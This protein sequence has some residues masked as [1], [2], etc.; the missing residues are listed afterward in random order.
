M[1]KGE[2]RR[3]KLKKKEKC[4]NINDEL[5]TEEK[6]NTPKKNKRKI[7]VGKIREY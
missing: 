2:E 4:E 7:G 6:R 5:P 1:R 3:E